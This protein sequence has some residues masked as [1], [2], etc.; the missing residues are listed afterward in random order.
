MQSSRSSG[1]AVTFI[2]CSFESGAWIHETLSH[3]QRQTII[4]KSEILVVDNNSC[5]AASASLK[6]TVQMELR[7]TQFRILREKTPGLMRARR[8]GV[9][10]AAADVIIFVDDDNFLSPNYGAHALE[11]L[12]SHRTVGAVGGRS[13]A[14]FKSDV[15]PPKWFADA[16]SEFACGS[17]ASDTGS[18]DERGYLWGAGLAVRTQPLQEAFSRVSPLLDGRTAKQLTAGDDSEICSWIQILG[19]GLHYSHDLTF[20]HFMPSSRMTLNTRNRQREGFRASR[21]PLSVYRLLGANTLGLSLRLQF[22]LLV[23][24]V[25]LVLCPS[26][27]KQAMRVVLNASALR[28]LREGR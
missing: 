5:L 21:T 26:G 2:L 17:Q 4:H 23:R 7:G 10:N 9:L 16:S 6:Q 20:R 25:P 3:L 12:E 14:A 27:F 8:T 11:Y 22:R 18:V 24:V 1:L 28:T 19:F 15:A 13:S